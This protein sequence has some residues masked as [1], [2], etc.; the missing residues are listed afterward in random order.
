M[1]ASAL[2]DEEKGVFDRMFEPAEDEEVGLIRG[3]FRGHPAAF[4]VMSWPAGHGR[5][6]TQPLAVLLRKRDMDDVTDAEGRVPTEH[7]A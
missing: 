4:I 6:A 1:P 3:F 2:T 7:D 5:V